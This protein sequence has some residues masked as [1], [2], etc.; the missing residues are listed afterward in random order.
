MKTMPG[1]W[2]A[3]EAA[4]VGTSLLLLYLLGFALITWLMG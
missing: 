1:I 3:R 4:W 2:G